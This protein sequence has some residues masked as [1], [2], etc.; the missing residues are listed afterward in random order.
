[1]RKLIV[2]E[3]EITSVRIFCGESEAEQY[4]ASELGRYFEKFGISADGEYPVRIYLDTQMKPDACR[5]SLPDEGGISIAGG[6]GRGAIYGVYEF[7][8]RYAGCRFFLPELETYGDGDIVV[9]QEWT[10]TPVFESRQSDWVCGDDLVWSV[11]N[12]I[13]NRYFPNHTI[14]PKKYGGGQKIWGFVHTLA[15]LTDTPAE[16]QPCLSDPENLDKTIRKVR[17]ILKEAPDTT[18]V[19]ISQNDNQRYCTCDRCNAVLAEEGCQSGILLRFVNAVADSVR[20]EYPN[21]VIETLA[22]HYTADP[23]LITKPRDNVCIRLCSVYLC[24]S[25]SILDD[26]CISNLDFR[27]QLLRWNEI[28]D[29]LYLWDYTTNFFHYIPT[30]PNFY[31]LRDTMRFYAE[32]GVKGIYPEGNYTSPASGEF[33]ELR[34]YLLARLMWDPFMTEQE[35][36]RHMDEFMA[37][38]YGEGWRFIRCYLDFVTQESRRY[39][40]YWWASETWLFHKDCYIPMEETLDGLWDKAEE[41]A[42]DRID[43]VKR[44]RMQWR[45]IKLMMH[46]DADVGRS[47]LEDAKMYGI[48]F[49]ESFG[50]PSDDADLS[51][52]PDMWTSKKL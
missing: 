15:E 32:H 21:V 38:Y 10:H 14:F 50:F 44:S 25:H 45:Y 46:P 47:F 8:E 5:I 49:K 24:P 28:C 36:L 26:T 16:V 20:E 1:M 41:M 42:G 33:G 22:Y 12:R 31:T 23:P 37:A 7:L 9:E 34:C 35:Y 40:T 48:H 11:K 13:N 3:E 27:N 43:A 52:T 19:S 4:A 30:F 39:H 18:V 2:K 29:R 51:L 17:N 6:N